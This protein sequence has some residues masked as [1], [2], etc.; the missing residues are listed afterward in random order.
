MTEAE[1]GVIS[2]EDGGRRYK[3]KS[4]ADHE[5]LKKSRKWIIS[6]SLQKEC[7]LANTLI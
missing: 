1:V 3:L 4:A 2:C 7:S 6:W 5:N